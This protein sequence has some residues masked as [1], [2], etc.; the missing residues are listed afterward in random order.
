MI[1]ISD[2]DEIASFER[3]LARV[4]SQNLRLKLWLLFFCTAVITPFLIAATTNRQEAVTRD[5]GDRIRAH[6]FE[7]V[8]DEGQVVAAFGINLGGGYLGLRNKGG[9]PVFEAKSDSLGGGTYL[10]NNS[11]Y[12]V[13]QLLTGKDG[14]GLGIAT[15]SGQPVGFFDT[16]ANG[17]ALVVG[18]KNGQEVGSFGA[19]PNGS[20]LV[21][22]D[23]VGHVLG[24]FRSG[25]SLDNETG[26][27]HLDRITRDGKIATV[28]SLSSSHNGGEIDISSLQKSMSIELHTIL[29]GGGEISVNNS[30]GY[31]GVILRGLD[32]ESNA[33]RLEAWKQGTGKIYSAP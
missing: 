24:I 32:I 22:K 16:G 12:L 15:N 7:V 18:N 8:N 13:A 1:P 14:G 30:T 26:E 5:V 33:G 10:Y 4:E 6:Q 31:P 19:V 17:S 3:R 27:L 23:N 9:K 11:G 29:G 25:N 2:G 28:V 20:A 21:I